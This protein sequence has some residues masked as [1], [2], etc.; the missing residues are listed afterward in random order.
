M[1]A[2][3]PI[4][5][6]WNGGEL[7]PLMMGRVDT[8]IYAIGAEAIENFCAAIEGPLQKCPGFRR[9]R[10]AAESS[11][12]LSRF[13]F[14][15]TQ[16]YVLECLE[17]KLRFYTNGGRIESD[18]DTP[19]EVVVPFA[20][21]E[22]PRVSMQQSYDVRYVAH[23]ASPP[24]ALTRTGAATF[25]YAALDL[26]NGPFGASNADEG[27]AV[28]VTGTL[29][30]GGA[31]TL[32]QVGGSGPIFAAG[33]AG[34]LFQTEA[35]DF[36]DLKAW[37]VGID[38]VVSGTT[39]VRSEGKAYV[40][41][42]NG[43]TGT[44]QPTHDE[45]TEWDGSAGGTDINGKGPYGV[46]WTYLYDSFG[47][48]RI[49][50]D[51]VALDGLSATGVVV[52]RVPESLATVASWHWAH[53]AFSAAAGWPNLVFTA[54]GRL[55]FWKGFE[56]YSSVAGDYRNFQQ[57]GSSG[58]LTD[59]LAFRQVLAA[60]DP[61]LWVKV[62]RAIVAGTASE[63]YV[64]DRINN[65]APFSGQNCEA[66]KQ[67]A[68]GSAPVDPVEPGE[69]IVYMQRGGRQFRE[70]SYDFGRDKYLSANINR[71]ARHIAGP[72]SR[73]VIQLGHQA[74]TEELLFA[75]RADGPLVL[76]SY[77]PEQEVK[78]FQRRVLAQGGAFL[79]AVAIPSDDG[80]RDDIWALCDW[81]G[82]K[83]VQKMADWWK[84]GEN[85]LTDAYFVDD[86]ASDDLDVASAT[87]SGLDWLVGQEVA[88]LADGAI[89]PRLTVP[90]SGTITLPKAAHRRVVG[91]PYRAVA[92]SLRPDVRDPSGQTAQG[93]L[94][95]MVG[96]VLRLLET[97]GILVNV[98]P[99][100]EGSREER[101][102]DRPLSA[103][104]DSAPPL[105]T[106]DTPSTSVGGD[107][108]R[109]GQYEIISEDPLPCFVVAAM[110]R[111]VVGDR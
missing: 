12:W 34:A 111:Y 2:Q 56:L 94:K 6:S 25:A 29:T 36:S 93:K 37:E 78:G 96:M 70:A 60:P 98:Q 85:S 20:A 10:A 32:A 39:I 105:F 75:V 7:S 26:L 86:G 8:A 4:T 47:I 81:G 48:V 40:A 59:D 92:R 28:T 76:R 67:S 5:T 89:V 66:R 11:T 13:V 58:Y 68:Y 72:S 108:E 64:I 79:S 84:P 104:M 24:G 3:T 33:H 15:N 99:G 50:E 71:W 57:F 14:N 87:I 22:W 31:V 63:E 61:P 49:D 88:I 45:G 73:G 54:F 106:G 83:S 97:A 53:G 27:V 35:Q 82:A 18:P 107:N 90:E 9:I 51:G 110:P 102:L 1:T 42:S 100:V 95:R 30:V 19:Y 69:T 103:P 43:R 21:D 44:V 77:D 101:L 80:S 109:A 46:Q 41:A 16:A 65:S 17:G 55:M 62:D 52:R 74:Q 23:G 38:G 91:R